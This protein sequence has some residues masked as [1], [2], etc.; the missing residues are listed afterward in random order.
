MST[1]QRLF[2]LIAVLILSGVCAQIRYSIAEE[3][4]EGTVVG[5]IAKDLG[6]DKATLK[7]RG[8]RIPCQHSGAP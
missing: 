3:V 1:V 4:K 5:N 6:L 2:A 8:Y 7:E